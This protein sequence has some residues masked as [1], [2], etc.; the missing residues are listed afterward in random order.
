MIGFLGFAQDAWKKFQKIPH[1]DSMVT[2][3][4]RLRKK[5]PKKQIQVNHEILIGEFFLGSL[6]TIC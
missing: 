3:P 6:Y 4:H 2:Y 5:T 1:G